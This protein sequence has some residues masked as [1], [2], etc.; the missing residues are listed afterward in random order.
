MIIAHTGH[1]AV[2][3]LY[4]APLVVVVLALAW[5]RLR[6]KHRENGDDPGD[7]EP[8]LDDILGDDR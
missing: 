2:Q 3:L 8:S 4:V 6:D 1:W 7:E 5:Q